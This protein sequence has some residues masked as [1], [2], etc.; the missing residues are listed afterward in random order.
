MKIIMNMMFLKHKES[1]IRGTKMHVSPKTLLLEA[2]M[3]AD[4]L[5]FVD[6]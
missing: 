4:D 6:F 5:N 2:K 3:S 1:Y